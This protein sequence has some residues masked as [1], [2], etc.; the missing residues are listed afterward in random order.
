[1][2]ILLLSYAV[3]P[4]FSKTFGNKKF[5]NGA[6]WIVGLYNELL[7]SKHELALISPQETQ[8][9][10]KSKQS[11]C[12]F[13][14]IPRFKNDIYTC[15]NNQQD[16]FKNILSEFIPDVITIFGTEFAQGLTML[17]AA[18][19]LGYDKKSVI[20]TQGLVSQ[21]AKHYTADLPTKIVKHKT[22]SELVSHMDIG[23][24]KKIF[25]KRGEI[26]KEMILT[27]GH[28][29][30]GTVWDKT[31]IK[32]INSKIKYHYCP[33]I[34]RNSFY[35]NS[36]SIEKC[37]RY[38]ILSVQSNFYPLK[39][40][41]YLLEGM[42]EVLK[43]YPQTKLYVTIDA[44]KKPVNFISWLKSHTY[45]RYIVGLMDKY[46]LWNNVIFIGNLKEKELVNYYLNSH[47]FIC[48]S[49][50]ENHSQTIS[51][52]KILGVP[53][54]ASFVGGVV[55]RINH[56]VDGFFYQHN[57]PSMIVEY[58]SRIFD[59]DELA[60]KLSKNARSEASQLLDKNNN[61]KTMLLIYEEILKEIN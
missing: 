26:E 50:I 49:S 43:K 9:L 15:D 11:N 30:G 16:I 61:I 17:R 58:V 44:P 37:E 55:E 35:L 53:T 56:G 51:E 5:T 14:A 60:Y 45:E 24:Q 4:A 25:L 33:E 1:M 3:I 22:A 36:W 2:K 54:I 40:M 42:H 29:I 32:N 38:S 39:G 10:E 31:I 12:T 23:S 8:N 19:E 21:I 48:P 13:Y 28:I 57:S 20:F 7:N 46:S 41:H 34:L 47:I 18:K 52:A 59:S 27:A 6:G